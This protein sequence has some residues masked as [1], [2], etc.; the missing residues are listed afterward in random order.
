MH[1][2][3]D[4]GL[5][6]AEQVL[7]FLFLAQRLRFDE[8][9]LAN[10]QDLGVGHQLALRRGLRAV[11][12][13]HAQ[14]DVA[15]LA[16]RGEGHNA[17]ACARRSAPGTPPAPGPATPP[18]STLRA[19]ATRKLLGQRRTRRKAGQRNALE[20]QRRRRASTRSRSRPAAAAAPPAAVGG[21]GR[22]AQTTT[23]TRRPGTTMIFFGARP[24]AN[25]AKSGLAM[26]AASIAARSACAHRRATRRASCR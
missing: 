11:L 15:H 21:V 2:Q 17:G 5:H 24:S 16:R 12:Q 26:A 13:P 23:F 14:L 8:G 4:V 19:S 6:F 7:F 10:E 18:P 25:L 1:L 9:H 3:H 20:L 22:Q